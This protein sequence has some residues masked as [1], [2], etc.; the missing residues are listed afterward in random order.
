M[1]GTDDDVLAELEVSAG[2]AELA[3]SGFAL[4]GISLALP[5]LAGHTIS[6]PSNICFFHSTIS[7]CSSTAILSL[8]VNCIVHMVGISG[9]LATSMQSYI[10]WDVFA[11]D[12]SCPLTIWLG[13]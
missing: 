6:M 7:S 4:A 13:L 5:C 1:G 8:K 2:A 12:D 11:F 9:D 10:I 3:S